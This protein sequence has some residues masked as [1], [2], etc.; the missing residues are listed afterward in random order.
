MSFDINSTR[1]QLAAVE[2]MPRVYSFLYDTFCKDGGAVEDNKAIWDYR[3]G[4]TRMAPVVHPGT[5]GVLM[6]RGGFETRE[7]DFCTIAPERAVEAEQLEGRSF[8]E[9]VL[10]ALTP[11]QRAK[12]MMAKDLMEMRQAIQRRIEWMSRQV[13]LNGKLEVFRY[14]NEGRDLQ[15]TCV[16]DYG[17]TNNYTPE[18]TW[19][20]AGAKIDYDM[21][22]TFDL[23]Y[24]GLG[25]VDT[26]VMDPEAAEAMLS[27][28]TYLSNLDLR[29]VNVG[30]INTR[31][32]GQ[33]VRFLGYNSD[34]AAMYSF[35]GKFIDDDG[36]PKPLL[37]KGTVIA[38]AS[39]ILKVPF[40]PITQVESEGA[41]AQ[42][43]TYIKKEVPL[44]Y[45][46]IGGNAVKQR[47]TSRPT[48]VPFNVDAWAVMHV[49]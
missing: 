33:G 24:D 1:A 45:G 11:A 18:T 16:A 43:N 34:G 42:H 32:R 17:F 9:K 21:R 31:Y 40:G 47:L 10:G 12:K 27:N 15:T 44:R 26:I 5:G 46:S 35:S 30:E 22:K 2:Q 38:G 41:T 4:L 3:K 39:D 13:L 37:P 19:D 48:I 49:L 25:F 8:G 29:H 6:E 28:S 23:V 14:T 36:L 20:N 7:I